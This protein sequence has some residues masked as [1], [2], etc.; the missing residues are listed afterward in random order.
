MQ[1]SKAYQWYKPAVWLAR[2]NWTHD[3]LDEKRCTLLNL[4]SHHH[5]LSI[6]Q[7]ESFTGWH[8]W[9]PISSNTD[10]SK[11]I[12]YIIYMYCYL[13]WCFALMEYGENCLFNILTL[14]SQCDCVGYWVIMLAAWSPSGDNLIKKPW[15]CN[16]PSWY[17]VLVGHEAPN[18]QTLFT[19]S[20]SFLEGVTIA[21]CS[22]VICLW[23]HTHLSLYMFNVWSLVHDLSC[24][25]QFAI[26]FNNF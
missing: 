6:H 23:L 8:G 25:F 11:P 22:D 14:N 19:A 3:L 16:Q 17:E 18:K 12:T 21:L 2:E 1:G 10:R 4:S 5:N 7:S 20:P 9:H 26:L 15:A 13:I 24:S